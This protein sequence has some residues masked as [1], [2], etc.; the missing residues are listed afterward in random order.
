MDAD[1]LRV[2]IESWP[3]VVTLLFLGVKA[4]REVV[5]HAN[6]LLKCR[7]EVDRLRRE[8]AWLRAQLAHEGPGAGYRKA[9]RP[10]STQVANSAPP[11]QGL[12]TRKG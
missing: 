10:Q 8:S 9:A 11:E 4:P 7:A 5:Q 2:L 1:P 12:D 6:T 3:I